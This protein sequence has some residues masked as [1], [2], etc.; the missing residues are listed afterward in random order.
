MSCITQG[1][2]QLA[3]RVNSFPLQVLEL[4]QDQCRQRKINLVVKILMVSLKQ[5]V[6]S[7]NGI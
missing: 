5:K 7:A 3:K 6:W 2:K 4:F 1:N